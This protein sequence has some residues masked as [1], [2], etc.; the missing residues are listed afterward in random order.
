M[1]FLMRDLIKKMV[2][3]STRIRNGFKQNKKLCLARQIFS[4]AEH[5]QCS[6]S[7]GTPVYIEEK[8]LFRYKHES[9]ALNTCSKYDD[10]VDFRA[11]LKIC[12]FSRLG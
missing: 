10:G 2:Q 5:K 4:Q 7:L 8:S 6:K 9:R 12:G 1:V 3:V 11:Y